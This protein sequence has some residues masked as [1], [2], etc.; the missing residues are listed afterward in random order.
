MALDL[1]LDGCRFNSQPPH[2]RATTLGKLFTPTCLCS[3]SGLVV[4]AWLRCEG[5]R[6][7]ISLWAV[8]F[9][10]SAT[11]IHSLGHGLHTLTAVPRLTQPSTIRGMVKQKLSSCWDGRLI[12]HKSGGLRCPFPWG[13]AG[14]PKLPIWHNVAW[15]KAY[16]HTKWYSDASSCLATIDMGRKVG[17]RQRAA[18][19]LFGGRGAGSPSNIMSPG[20]RP[21][22]IPSGIQP[23]GHNTPTLQRHDR[24]MDRQRDNGPIP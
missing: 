1:Q 12:S 15:A 21:T 8:V 19:P 2:C 10:I 4:H 18:V 3:C 20:L 11:V 14:S 16:L 6:F 5:T 7:R 24:Q 17:G 22:S 9:I 13:A 23:F